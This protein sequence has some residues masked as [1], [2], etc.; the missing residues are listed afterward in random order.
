M[1]RFVWLLLGLPIILSACGVDSTETYEIGLVYEGGVIEDKEYRGILEPGSTANP[2]GLGSSVYRYRTDQRTYI[3]C[4]EGCDTGPIEIV[5]RDGVRMIVYYQLYFKLN[6]DEAT[7][8]AFHENLGVKTAAWTDEG[9]RQLLFEYFAPQIERAMEDAARTRDW[10]ALRSDEVART[11]FRNETVANLKRN[12]S[13]VIGRDYFCGPAYDG[14][15]TECGEFTFTIGTPVPVNEAIVQAVEAEQTAVAETVAQE[16]R[17]VRIAKE[18]E[19]ERAL[20]D[21]YGPQGALLRDAIESGRVQLMVV[22]EGADVAVPV[23]APPA[24]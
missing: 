11:E 10:R 21:L 23:P 24:G 6:L 22:P 19:I 7:L 16:Q 12:V 2:I 4:D 17:N 8:R 5:S 18:L 9:W 1:K 3:A 15:G 14:P 13:E 20:V